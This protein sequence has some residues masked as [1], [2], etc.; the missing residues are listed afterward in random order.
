MKK[1]TFGPEYVIEVYDPKIGMEGFLVI[2]NTVRGPGK[3]G[4]RMSPDVTAQE[5][6]R[7][8]R[9]MT[10][11]TALADIPFGGAKAGI[12]WNGG[13]D[14]LKKKYIQSFARAIKVFTPKKYIAAPD[15]KVGEK[16]IKWFVEAADDWHAATGKPADY[17]I[18]V[19]GKERKKCGIPHEF[20]STGFGVAHATDVA[21]T[22]LKY[23]KK[24]ILIA[25]EGFGNVGSFAFTFLSKM[26][27]KIVAL[28]DSKG[29]AFNLSGFDEKTLKKLK[30]LG[31]SVSDYP[32]V[33]VLSRQEF[34]HLPVDILI[35]AGTTDVINETNKENIKAKLIVEGSN[36]PMS[37]KIEDDLFNKGIVIVPD[38]VANGGGLISSYAE[39]KGIHPDKMYGMI[40]EKI[41]K[42]TQ[43]VLKKSLK[44]NENPRQVALAI[45]KKKLL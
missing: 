42:I 4:M 44:S 21:A 27:Y 22:I 8:A 37:E 11:K 3:G 13:P 25:I 18:Q 1:D 20:G 16:E 34:L 32:K 23:N 35:T 43:M 40:E 39:Y 38:F 14:S 19:P 10:W 12:V 7:L 2:D 45:A 9:V 28:A 33:Q 29:A 41:R 6:F 36:I 15:I 17:C 26:G 30:S 5:V 24:K 31:K